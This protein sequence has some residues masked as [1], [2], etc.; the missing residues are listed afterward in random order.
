MVDDVEP[1]S[2]A[3]EAR[4]AL[5]VSLVRDRN[6]VSRVFFSLQRRFNDITRDAVRFSFSFFLFSVATSATTLRSII[7]S[8]SVNGEAAS[9]SLDD[10][11]GFFASVRKKSRKKK[12]RLTVILC[13]RVA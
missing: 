9:S 3:I 4:P 13:E 11:I 6:N 7:L 1:G 5:V 8:F 12:K 10:S 2:L